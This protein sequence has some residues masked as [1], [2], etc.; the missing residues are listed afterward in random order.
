MQ[1][2]RIHLNGTASA[3]LVQGY[4]DAIYSLNE[5]ISAVKRAGPNDRDYYVIGPEAVKLA[6]TEHRARVQK[7]MDIW[8]ELTALAEAIAT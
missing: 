7:L 6:H 2:P 3:E 4:A 8:R 1:H 5:A